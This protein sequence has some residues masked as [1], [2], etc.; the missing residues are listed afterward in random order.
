MYMSKL[1]LQNVRLAFPVI[2]KAEQYKGQGDF[3]FSA[4]FLCD[5]EEQ[6]SHI[7]KIKKAL[8]EV[9]AE[10]WE[11]EV[12][13]SVQFDNAKCCAGL[14]NS[15]DKVYDGFGDNVYIRASNKQRPKLLDRSKNIVTEEDGIIY[16][17]CFVNVILDMWAQDNAFGKRVNC[18]LQA[19]QFVRNGD[20]FGGGAIPDNVAD[21]FDDISEEADEE[22]EDMFD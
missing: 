19:I 10:K 4:T 6:K 21:D 20:A 16:G 13:K 8:E 17:G 7:R 22:L 1:I 18:N 12:P 3:R 2:H 11:D 15:M 14:G 9:A 5:G